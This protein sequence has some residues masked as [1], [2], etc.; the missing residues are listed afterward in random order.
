VLSG[1]SAVGKKLSTT[2]GTWNSPVTIAFQWLRC[3]ADG[4]GCTAVPGATAS[5]YVLATAD[6]GHTFEA[7]ISATNAA[8]A[9]A[10]L[11]NRSTV[12]VASPSAEKPPHIS[13]RAKVGKKLS[14]GHGSWANSPTGYRFQW[15][16]CN[17]H[18]GSCGLIGR[19]THSS[20]RLTSHD[21][22]HR[23]RLRVTAT[24]AAGSR[25]ATSAPTKRVA[26]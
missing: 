2:S 16:R 5:T 6:S 4:S 13:G 9:T 26:H 15:L 23:L 19:A 20:Y 10:A 11:S 24:N 18:G 1:V 25:M 22:G 14:G 17:A 12:V 7:R 8:G 3:A 21:A